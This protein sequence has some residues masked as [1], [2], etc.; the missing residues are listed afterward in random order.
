MAD[1]SLAGNTGMKIPDQVN[2][3]SRL[4]NARETQCNIAV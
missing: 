4:T 1:R 2:G 3:Y